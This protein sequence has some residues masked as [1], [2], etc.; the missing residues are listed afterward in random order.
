[1]RAIKFFYGPDMA[2]RKAFEAGNDI[3][4]FRFNKD[5]ER[6]VLDKIEYLVK[7]AK[8]KESRINKSVKWILKIKEKY[9]IS[10]L[11]SFDGVNVEEIN[12]EIE[13]IRKTC[14]I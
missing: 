5:E 10:D 14:K 13:E 4:V 3:I 8:I 9:N 2:V 1:M 7:T 12:K 11:Q 6:R